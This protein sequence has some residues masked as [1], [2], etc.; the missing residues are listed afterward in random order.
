MSLVSGVKNKMYRDKIYKWFGEGDEAFYVVG[1]VF[2]HGKIAGDTSWPK[3]TLISYTEIPRFTPM[4]NP[5]M[6]LL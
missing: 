4:A 2:I 1:C 5:P 6:H 3:F